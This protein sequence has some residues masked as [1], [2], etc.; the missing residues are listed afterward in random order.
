MRKS[1]ITVLIVLLL[2]A[3]ALGF[4]RGWFTLSSPDAAKGSN[5]VNVNL[6]MDRDKIEDDAE[7]VKN[8][9]TELTGNATTA[10]K[11][12]GEQ[13]QDDQPKQNDP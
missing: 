6:T 8:K 3:V 2:G 7:M 12:P 11:E 4:Y 13:Q 10:A 9:A 1:I 5:K